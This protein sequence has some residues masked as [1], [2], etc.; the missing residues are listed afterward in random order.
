MRVGGERTDEPLSF[1][2]AVLLTFVSR[3][4]PAPS[5]TTMAALAA[6]KHISRTSASPSVG[7]DV[8]VLTASVPKVPPLLAVA[9]VSESMVCY[10]MAA[11]NGLVGLNCS[12][13]SIAFRP[14]A[15]LRRLHVS[16]PATADTQQ[17][18]YR[19]PP[20]P[21]QGPSI[22]Q[23]AQRGS[24]QLSLET[25]K[26]KVGTCSMSSVCYGGNRP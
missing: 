10:Y 25:P 18:D 9:P 20:V 21:P 4:S 3:P 12:W 7:G 14:P 2:W 17:V 5:H 23:V 6:F 15:S 8:Y 19:G 26:N 1:D 11:A 13:C 16:A 24:M 22:T